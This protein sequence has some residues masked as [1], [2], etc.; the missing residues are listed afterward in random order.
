MDAGEVAR[1]HWRTRLVA[2]CSISAAAM[3]NPVE[4]SLK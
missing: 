3:R 4:F 1:S 2:S